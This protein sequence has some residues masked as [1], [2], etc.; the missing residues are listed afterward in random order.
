M[1]KNMGSADRVIRVI[2]G[3]VL[4]SLV[5]VGPQTPWGWIG[6]IPLVT[7]AIGV[8]PLYSIIGIKTCPTK[9]S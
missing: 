3:L 4:L 2:I 6:I 1:T 9:R 7:A 5:F 8:C